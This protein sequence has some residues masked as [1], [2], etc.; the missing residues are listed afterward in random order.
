MYKKIFTALIFILCIFVFT[1]DSYSA[2][3]RIYIRNC[4]V[5]ESIGC[6]DALDGALPSPTRHDDPLNDGDMAI[7]ITRQND[8]SFPFKGEEF[9]LDADSGIVESTPWT[10]NNVIAPDTNPSTKRW[11]K[12][13]RI[14]EINLCLSASPASGNFLL[15]DSVNSCWDIVDHTGNTDA[16]HPQS[17][18][19]ASHND[20]TGTGSELNNLTD[21]SNADSLHDHTNAS[22]I[23]TH[24]STTGQTTDDHHAETHTIVSHDTGATGAELDTLTDDSMA[25]ALHRHSELS[26]SDGTPNQ[27]VAVDAE[28]N[29]TFIGDIL[30]AKLKQP[31]RFSF[32][33]SGG[34]H[35][36]LD[37]STGS[38]D[39]S[40]TFSTVVNAAIAEVILDG[41]SGEKFYFKN[42]FYTADAKINLPNT[43]SFVIEG[44]S[45]AGTRITLANGVND[46]LLEVAS[47]GATATFFPTV[48]HISLFGNK[49]NNTSGR[50]ISF[51]AAETNDHT[52]FD[53]YIEEFKEEG[54][55]IVEAWNSRVLSSTI[56]HCDGYQVKTDGGQDF[57]MTNSKII[58]PAGGCGGGVSLGSSHGSITN[59]F[60]YRI[61]EHALYIDAVSNSISGN[62][63]WNNSFGNTDTY[64][65]IFITANGDYTAISGANTFN[66]QSTTRYGVNISAAGVTGT[67]VGGNAFTP[68]TY[69]T[70]PVV[71]TGTGSLIRDNYGYDTDIIKSST[72]VTVDIG[73]YLGTNQFAAASP[74]GRYTDPNFIVTTTGVANPEVITLQ[75]RMIG[76]TTGTAYTVDVVIATDSDVTD[77]EI[78]VNYIYDLMV[79]GESFRALTYQAKTDQDPT[80]ATV[81]VEFFG[82]G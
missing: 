29:V 31:A 10:T 45:A 33:E 59:T 82:R 26:A 2:S 28:G 16:H 17:H 15:Y 70:G 57:K 30:A 77:Y 7:V 54:I 9:T 11:V 19:I 35:Y 74:S 52:I 78:P 72:A 37:H 20:T 60:F 22:V 68:A 14:G 3:S 27:A 47:A 21:S 12:T 79:N 34:T 64:D 71:D 51:E 5:G 66:G 61:G 73:S 75:L 67:N 69:A 48:A 39:Y 18:T 81:T 38:T 43:L 40:G 55:Y 1:T 58:C 42:G 8:A 56:E 50:G 65:D 23:V 49:A 46:D 63:F 80:S 62:T 6:L 36:A 76:A 25:D 53:V 32:Y 41:I 44:E 13:N 4:F 24:A